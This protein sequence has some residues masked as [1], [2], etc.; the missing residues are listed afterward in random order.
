MSENI[1]AS[2]DY[3]GFPF[4][5]FSESSVRVDYLLHCPSYFL[6]I[7]IL[8]YFI[9]SFVFP[10]DARP[11]RSVK[12]MVPAQCRRIAFGDALVHVRGDL[13]FG[14]ITNDRNMVIGTQ[15]S[16]VGILSLGL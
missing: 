7:T 12:Y 15:W 11:R 6:C 16:T 1:T 5:R 2:R 8:F 9:C 14:Y 13:E 4:F 10:L 3:L